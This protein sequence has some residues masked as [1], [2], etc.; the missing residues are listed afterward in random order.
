M[1]LLEALEC[2]RWMKGELPTARQWDKAAGLLDKATGPFQGNP[3]DLKPGDI[4]V[5][6]EGE[7]PMPVGKA[8]RDVSMFGCRD[9]AGNGREWTCTLAQT[10]LDRENAPVS[11]SSYKDSLDIRLRGHSYRDDKPY[12]FEQLPDQQ[13]AKNAEPDIS[14]RV[15]IG[16]TP[17]P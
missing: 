6:R 9:M 15:V 11:L 16:I 7:G 14:F 1:T 12:L 3:D 5:R 10:N 2:A 8:R 4:A 13:Q 17:L